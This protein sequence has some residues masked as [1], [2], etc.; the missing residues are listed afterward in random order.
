M[1]SSKANLLCLSP[2]TVAAALVV[3]LAVVLP[4]NGQ[5]PL[6]PCTA[7]MLTS[8]T[9]CMNFLSNSTTNMTTPTPGCCSSLKSLASNGTGCLCQILSGGVPFRMP[10]N[11]TSAISLPKSCNMAGVPLQ[12]NS[13]TGAPAPAP[14]P[15]S[16]PAALSPTA[17]SSPSPSASVIPTVSSPSPSESPASDV[18]PTATSPTD[19][20]ET[21]PT[22][23]SVT[24]GKAS[25]TATSD[26]Q[27]SL[28]F[29]PSL[30]LVPVAL[31][32]LKYY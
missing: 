7:S 10:I 6:S 3:I 11:R 31:A 15:G 17:A 2:S 22:S 27:S 13:P 23:S 20:T 1:A 19:S 18:T 9:P 5:T 28:H 32:M 29:S 16:S 8:F 21:T 14:A 26:A 30:L 24:P 4:T 12:C 25:N